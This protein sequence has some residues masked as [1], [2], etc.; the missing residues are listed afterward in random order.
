MIY[1]GFWREA[2]Q[3]LISFCLGE[4][5]PSPFMLREMIVKGLSDMGWRC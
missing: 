4:F 1:G 3:A 5:L 2:I